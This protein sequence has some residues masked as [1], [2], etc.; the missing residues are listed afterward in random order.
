MSDKYDRVDLQRTGE[1]SWRVTAH[2]WG[3][4][5]VHHHLR[6]LDDKVPGGVSDYAVTVEGETWEQALAEL[7]R[8]HP[9]VPSAGWKQVVTG[10]ARVPHDPERWQWCHERHRA[11]KGSSENPHV[12]VPI[13]RGQRAPEPSELEVMRQAIELLSA[14]V[15]ELAASKAELPVLPA[16]DGDS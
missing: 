12:A 15:R 2:Q 4:S 16:Q 1:R 13:V 11:R 7:R 3:E 8:L 5:G 6:T 9:D 10:P 14:Q